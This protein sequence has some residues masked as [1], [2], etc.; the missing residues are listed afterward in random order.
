MRDFEDADFDGEWTGPKEL[1]PPPDQ[2][3]LTEQE[4]KEEFTRV[5]TADNPHA[6]PNI[7]RF[8]F[9]EK[10]FK[11]VSYIWQNKLTVVTLFHWCFFRYLP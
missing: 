11:Q 1:V 4:L 5:L 7:V 2:L 6:P 10:S 9:K 3:Q 8:N